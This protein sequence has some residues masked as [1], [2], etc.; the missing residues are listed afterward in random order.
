MKKFEIHIEGRNGFKEITTLA[1]SV[2]YFV[3]ESLLVTCVVRVSTFG[4]GW[5]AVSTYS[6]YVNWGDVIDVSSR[7]ILVI[8]N[9]K[10][11]LWK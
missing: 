3:L 10:T 7:L 6:M 4:V 11:D 5:R 2:I 1:W 8:L 9:K